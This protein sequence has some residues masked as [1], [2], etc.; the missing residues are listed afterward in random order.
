MTG[1]DGEPTAW[2][3]DGCV[4]VTGDADYQRAAARWFADQGP[5]ILSF[6]EP[7]PAG[8]IAG[9]PAVVSVGSHTVPVSAGALVDAAKPSLEGLRM[10]TPEDAVRHIVID[11]GRIVLC[12]WCDRDFTDS[13]ESGGFVFSGYATGPCCAARIQRNAERSREA[14]LI[15]S[16]C[17]DG[18][19]FA[20][21]VR[22]TVRGPATPPPPG[23]V[24]M[25]IDAARTTL[26]EV[27]E[28]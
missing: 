12:D 16:R 8:E 13:A 7:T 1:V 15:R 21:W 18:T 26:T 6:T 14:Y 25:S 2:I 22:D 3:P 20:D 4:G 27:T 5:A 23:A 9:P 24:V 17:P 11:P 28:P 19:A 10:A